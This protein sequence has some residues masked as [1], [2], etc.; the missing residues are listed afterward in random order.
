MQEHKTKECYYTIW[1]TNNG[2]G[3]D[4]AVESYVI[5]DANEICEQLWA[6]IKIMR[7]LRVKDLR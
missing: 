2:F 3:L 4:E 5:E 1:Y 7:T 6:E